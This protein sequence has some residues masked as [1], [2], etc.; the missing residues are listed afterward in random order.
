MN[1]PTTT[2]ESNMIQMTLNTIQNSARERIQAMVDHNCGFVYHNQDDESTDM[3][4]R[5]AIASEMIYW[6]NYELN[7]RG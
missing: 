7:K 5:V 2:K 3:Q 4:A 6:G 1:K